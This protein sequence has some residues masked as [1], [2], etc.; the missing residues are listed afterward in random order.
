MNMQCYKLC[1]VLLMSLTCCVQPRDRHQVLVLGYPKTINDGQR[2]LGEEV[3]AVGHN[4]F[5]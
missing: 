1:F 2:D 3:L 5:S 4:L